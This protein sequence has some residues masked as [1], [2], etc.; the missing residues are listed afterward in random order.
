MAGGA[1]RSWRRRS[2]I[3][4]R[5]KKGKMGTGEGSIGAATEGAG[6]AG[7][8]GVAGVAGEVAVGEKEAVTEAASIETVVVSAVEAVGGVAAVAIDTAEA[9]VQHDSWHRRWS[10]LTLVSGSRFLRVSVWSTRGWTL[11]LAS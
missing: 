8:A 10:Q 3:L 11:Q 9:V 7:A 1:G 2:S 6:A 5:G 4:L